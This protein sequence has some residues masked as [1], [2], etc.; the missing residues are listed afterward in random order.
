MKNSVL[1]GKIRHIFTTSLI[2]SCLLSGTVRAEAPDMP[3]EAPIVITQDDYLRNDAL[4]RDNSEIKVSGELLNADEKEALLATLYEAEIEDV[5]NV[6]KSGL[7][8]CEEVTEYFIERINAYNPTYK[9]FITL[10]TDSALVRARELDERL[11]NGDSEG[12]LFGVPVVVKDNI[13][14]AG[15]YTTNGHKFSESYIADDNA[16]VVDMILNQGAVILGKT[17]M[18]VDAQ[19]A[20]YSYSREAGQTFN[21]YSTALTSGGSSGGSA[22]AVSLNFC[23]AGLGTDTNSSLRIPAAMNGCVAMRF[24]SGTIDRDGIIIL[25]S[26]RDV[27]GAITRTVKDN[28][29]MADIFTGFK[30]GYSTDLDKDALKGVRIGVLKELVKRSYSDEENKAAFQN[31]LTELEACGAILVDVSLPNLFNYSN[32]TENGVSGATKTFLQ[33]YNDMLVKYDV[34]AVVYASYLSTPFSSAYKNGGLVANS[35]DWVNNARPLASAIGIPEISVPIGNHSLGAGLGMEISSTKNN[36][37]LL[38]NM[39]YSYTYHFD[40]RTIPQGT[41]ELTGKETDKSVEDILQTV[42]DRINKERDAEAQNAKAEA[43]AL[44]IGKVKEKSKVQLKLSQK[45]LK[46]PFVAIEDLLEEVMEQKGVRNSVILIVSVSIFLI[47]A[48]LIFGSKVQK[49]LRTA[50]PKKHRRLK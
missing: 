42:E 5:T 25:N 33:A 26:V 3:T 4:F 49:F 46:R 31:A 35:Q 32:D 41:P 19:S 2:V 22:V 27:P 7:L 6:I 40:H 8:T 17:N 23:F 38:F 39:A 44:V 11:K 10:M 36:E 48:I 12:V 13:D 34:E 50:E 24:T 20:R 14:V 29:I 47:G 30:N 21:A 18:S 15:V 28:A 9:C 43:A 37:K 1:R 45:A 16:A